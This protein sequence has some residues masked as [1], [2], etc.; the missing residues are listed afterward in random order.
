MRLVV[1][2]VLL[3]TVI[4]C[5]PT[6]TQRY[7]SSGNNVSVL[8]ELYAKTPHKIKVGEFEGDKNV[9]GCRGPNIAPPDRMTYA[10]FIRN[11]LVEDLMLAN[12]HSDNSDIDLS[13]S[14]IDIDVSCGIGTGK[15]IIEME[16]A[17]QGMEA[18]TVKNSYDFEGAIIG[19]TVF[20]NAN[21][22]LVPAIQEFIRVVINH[23][24][25]QSAD[26]AP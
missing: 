26:L 12:V 5:A 14:L 7:V 16:L 1:I 2:I 25:F 11:A 23:P 19:V 17:I 3:L 13:G 21:L 8:R 24:K 9:V 15:W 18:F 22:A 6:I 10:S 20:S 4:G